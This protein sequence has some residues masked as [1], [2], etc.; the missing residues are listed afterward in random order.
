[1]AE[2]CLAWCLACLMLVLAIAPRAEGAFSSSRMLENA[3]AD[4]AADLR[5]VRI[6]LETKA[7][8]ARL[9]ALGFSPSEIGERLSRMSDRELHAAATHLEETKTGG[10]AE[11]LIIGVAVI[12][13][14][15]LVILP[16]LGVRIWR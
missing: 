16:L 15:I 9:A 13:L 1:M 10:T 6:V 3:C 14:V 11:G 12:I 8:R 4:R 7:V 2:K 5:S